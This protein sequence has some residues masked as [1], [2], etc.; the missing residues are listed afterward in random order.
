MDIKD[1][2]S[3]NP[4]LFSKTAA[5]NNAAA[6]LGSGFANLLGQT[7]QAFVGNRDEAVDVSPKAEKNVARENAEDVRA[8]RREDK[9]KSKNVKETAKE[10]TPKQAKAKK[11]ENADVS[12]SRNNDVPAM[13]TAA[14]P[15]VDAEVGVAAGQVRPETAAEETAAAV[16]ED[17]VETAAE[18]VVPQTMAENEAVNGK[19]A[20]QV[21]A[22][23]EN[24]KSGE[25][26]AGLEA[27][28]AGEEVSEVEASAAEAAV[29]P[30]REDVVV[31]AENEKSVKGDKK[32]VAE[33]VAAVDEG[34]VV[35][36]LAKEQSARLSEKVENKQQLK[37]S[38]N[39]KEEKIAYQT[40]QDTFKSRIAIDEA[41]AAANAEGADEASSGDIT[42]AA[43]TNAQPQMQTSAAGAYTAPMQNLNA[44][45]VETISAA[46]SVEIASVSTQG[47]QTSH[48]MSGSEFVAAAK[49]EAA[50]KENA[51][52]FKEVYKGMS[53]EAVDQVKVNITKSAVK[54]IDKIDVH[55]KPEELGRIEIKMQIG[56]DG[57]LQAHIIA[58]RPETVE[59]LQK[60]VQSLEKAFNDAGFQT[61][62][63]SLSFSF[64]DD[65]QSGRNQNNGSEL[66]SFIGSVFE[67]EANNELLAA[68]SDIQGW[69]SDKGLN[70]RV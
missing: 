41:V 36:S 23:A 17:V 68:N 31:V 64:R 11:N 57:K 7:T 28:V 8:P 53:K 39:V 54:G 59:M 18:N 50:S 67:Q 19:E 51:P 2:N 58:N 49:T 55:L 16:V 21:A 48:V 37:V 66:R 60:E 42:P 46:R 56:K 6:A 12:V 3:A 65:G 25:N 63:G 45:V 9:E 20:A 27:V 24:I 13:Q 5:I 61:D 40:A 32:N 34:E 47:G 44:P 62:E 29:L 33:T 38:V 69:I 4:L 26:V 35:D 70:I 43:N 52:S 22:P 15:E 1:V 30:E 14:K 10:K